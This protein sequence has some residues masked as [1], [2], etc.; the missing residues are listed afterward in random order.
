MDAHQASENT[1]AIGMNSLTRSVMQPLPVMFVVRIRQH[2]ARSARA[3]KQPRRD[4]GSF[5]AKP[6]FTAEELAWFRAPIREGL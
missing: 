4:D 5:V 3:R 2:L 1:P 6:P